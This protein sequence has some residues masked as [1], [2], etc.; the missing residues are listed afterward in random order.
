MLTSRIGWIVRNRAAMILGTALTMIPGSCWSAAQLSEPGRHS[1]PVPS[2]VGFWAGEDAALPQGGRKPTGP[3]TYYDAA[4]R[5]D[6]TPEVWRVLQDYRVPIYLNV[7]YGRDFGPVQPGV[8]SDVVELVRK[9]NS[10]GVPV[11]AWIV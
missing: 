3:A 7:R 4:Y 11:S 2:I 8:Q 10:V 9:A 5:G 1:S 6:F